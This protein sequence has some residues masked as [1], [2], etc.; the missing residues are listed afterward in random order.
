MNRAEQIY[1][2]LKKNY[3]KAAISLNY[4]SPWQLLVATIL[5]A[6]CTDKRVN[7]ITEKLFKDY[8]KLSSY[9]NMGKE[10]LVKYIRS[11]GLYNNKAKSILGS[12]KM[13]S[14]NFNDKV[15]D[16]MED[17]IKLPGVARKTA[18]VV[19]S[20]AYGNIEGI[21]V[22]THVKR[23]SRRLGLTSQKN[24]DKIEADLMELYSKDKWHSLNYLLIEHGRS[25]CTSRATGTSSGRTGH[26]TSFGRTGHGTSFGRTGHGTSSG[27]TGHGTSSGRTPNCGECFLS[28]LCPKKGV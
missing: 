1:N 12:A 9:I 28:E 20:N 2:L 5:S 17:L 3:P 22:D 19:L 27:R 14:N 23:L 13:I 15:P 18:N 6:Q 8:P 26:G 16:T 21:A 11:A 10:T 24:T 4:S 7:I 25:I